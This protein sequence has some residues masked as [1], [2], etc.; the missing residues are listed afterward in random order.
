MQDTTTNLDQLLSLEKIRPILQRF[1]KSI[2]VGCR[3]VNSMGHM[4]IEEGWQCYCPG[5]P[6]K[7]NHP[8]IQSCFGFGKGVAGG[9]SNNTGATI[10]TCA[11]GLNCVTAPIV[12]DG[13]HLA[14]IYLGLFHI[15][16][17][18][19][20]QQPAVTKGQKSVKPGE[21]R[22]SVPVFSADKL[23]SSMDQVE[24]V[25]ALLGEMACKSFLEQQVN[26]QLAC[27]EERYRNLVDSLPTMIYETDLRGRIIFANQSALDTFGYT[28]EEVRN[29]IE[30]TK[31][32]PD[33][34]H[35]KVSVRFKTV[36]S[37][38]IQTPE[39]YSFIRKDSSSFPGMVDSR[40]IFV[41][42]KCTGVR[43]I[44]IDLTHRK[45][46]DR[47]VRESE[48]KLQ[49]LFQAVPV[50]LTILQDRIFRS[51]NEK[52]CKITGFDASELL[53]HSS[54]HLYES[55][56][57]FARVG[58]ALYGWTREQGTSYT[59]TR[60]RH[61]DGSWRDVAL[62]AAFLNFQD[63]SLGAAVAI[64]DI[65]AQKQLFNTLRDNEER[66]RKTA[67]FTGQLIYDHNIRTGAIL[68]SGRVQAITGYSPEE[69]HNHG[70][71]G[72]IERI[73][74]EDR[75]RI[76]DELA[77]ARQD[78]VVF[79][80][81][82]RFLKANN[83]YM[84]VYE[85]GAYIYDG[86]GQPIR[87]LGT[88]KDVTIKK[89]R[90]EALRRSE[91]R[92]AVAVNA[93]SDAIWEWY[94]QSKSTYFSPRWYE[95]L[96]Y[97]HHEFPMN[98]ETWEKLCHPQDYPILFENIQ[99]A[100]SSSAN[101]GFTVEFR[102]HHRN[103][104]WEWVLCRGKVMQRNADGKPLLIAGTN[105]NISERKIAEIALLESEQRYKT[106]FEAAN[107]VILAKPDG[108]I[109]DCN[110]M[111][112]N[113]FRC[114]RPE[115]LN[116]AL[117]DIFKFSEAGDDI[118]AAQEKQFLWPALPKKKQT[119]NRRLRRYDGDIFDAEIGICFVEL[120]GQMVLQAIIHD[121]SER[122]KLE[123]VLKEN[124]FRFRSFFNT[125]PEGIILI[126]FQ[127]KI[128]DANKAFL[129]E[130][131]YSIEEFKNKFFREFIP[132]KEQAQIIEAI[133]SLKSGYSHTDSML[134]S[135]IA[136]GGNIIPI[137]AKGWLV[138]D[139]KSNPLYF[140]LF[141]RNLTEKLNLV[142][143]K[144][145]LEKQVIQAQ[146][147]EAIGT[148][149]G[150]IAHDFNNILGGILGY[151]ELALMREPAV[152]DNTLRQYL[153][154]VLEGGNRA[155][156]LVQQILRFSRNSNMVMEPIHLVP[157][158]SEAIRLLRSTIPTTIEIK[159]QLETARDTILGDS[160]Q[161]HQVVTNLVTNAY[162][163]MRET[164]GVITISLENV[165]LNTPKQFLSMT[166]PPGEYLRLRVNDNGP[167]MT[168]VVLERVFEPYFTT[169]NVNEGTGLGM[170]VVKG[171]VK[172]HHGLIEIETTLGK[173]TSFDVF[174]PLT[175]NT[176]SAKENTVAKLPLGHGERVLIVDDE[177]Y[178][179]EV[180]GESLKL[181]GYQVTASQSSVKTLKTFRDDPDGYDLLITDQTMPE[182]TGV[183]LSL[184]VRKIRNTI[185][186]ILCTG[187][188]ELVTEQSASYYGITDYLMKPVNIYDLAQAI[189]KVL[190]NK[191]N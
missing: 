144:I 50:G 182:M 129:Q 132:E 151:T 54:R 148:L 43:G 9:I 17:S 107:P 126:D 70:I 36:L 24:L 106:L 55:D 143:E 103:G 41:D 133:L 66:F 175:W 32:L 46:A 169:K 145:A 128:I 18:D 108:E 179:L 65:T 78:N 116:L 62:S 37:G 61:K 7:P 38:E 136:K 16:S 75:A 190:K 4:I 110:E 168:P 96:G 35:P 155:K 74:P 71:S 83:V 26:Q 57:E 181:L 12:V 189:E 171:I 164:G 53:N 48:E 105:S 109:I 166:L 68:W 77:T 22:P 191:A 159:H 79:T 187:Y 14:R 130:S 27:R 165:V 29:G 20:T 11:N 139:E 163:A 158:L 113:L 99:R 149:A 67:E 185:P 141:V 10:H 72:W 117:T 42:E 58:A 137:A 90:E 47:K 63:S 172:S 178:F 114:S 127:G 31:F 25:G 170:A 30:L 160:T 134:Y 111:A 98:M 21:A 102:M 97:A 28:Q 140:G 88:I 34:E 84:D 152:V 121:I 91:A 56:E 23:Q 40:A 142:N 64:Q 188:S 150:G 93:A 3:I 13:C 162:H 118:F 8:N 51:V 86:Q 49:S 104:Q 115:M 82:Y 180:V 184:E 60:F 147:N 122:K 69:L 156:N 173:G 5:T 177:A 44:I 174:L 6:C 94:P 80:G 2:G 45:E 95:M 176:T 153:E 81:Y 59:E 138:V 167:G 52:M 1:S 19:D 124:E 131:G 186:I 89:R 112:A 73:H 33:H 120:S 85:E 101:R 161:L 100:L 87:M 125:N 157:V 15:A 146:K 119:F 76:L 123:T 183:Q 154:H 39:E 92:L 135:Y